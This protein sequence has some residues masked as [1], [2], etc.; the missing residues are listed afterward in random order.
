MGKQTFAL[1]FQLAFSHLNMHRIWL[2]V[3]TDN[4]KAIGLYKKLGF[5]TEGLLRECYWDGEKFKS[6]YLMSLLEGEVG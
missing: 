5:K 2:D 4:E 6:L 3:F 1:V